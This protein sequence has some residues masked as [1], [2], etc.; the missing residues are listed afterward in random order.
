MMGNTV[1]LPLYSTTK[2]GKVVPSKSGLNQWLAGGRR[3]R[4]GECYFPVPAV[5]HK[6]A[7]D[8]FPDK[9]CVF[10]LRLPDGLDSK[11]KL[12]Q[13][14]SK[15]LMTSPNHHLGFWLF[16]LIDQTPEDRWQRYLRRQPYTFADLESLGFDS[17]SISEKDGLYTLS[18]ATL[19]AYELWLLKSKG[20]KL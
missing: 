15:A 20:A 1:F 9:D 6:I 3:R 14:G 8:F 18:P 4:P 7:A 13:Q 10:T 2:S 11:A 16:S 19:D 12:C 5:V 17:V